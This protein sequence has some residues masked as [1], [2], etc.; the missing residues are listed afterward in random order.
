MKTF[1]DVLKINENATADEIVNAYNILKEKYRENLKDPFNSDKAEELLKKLEIAFKVLGNEENRK[2]YDRDLSNA[3]ANELMN[4]LQKNTDTYN[5]EVQKK[6]EL[7][8]KEVEEIKKKESEQ[9]VDDEELQKEKQAK[10]KFVQNEIEKQIQEQQKQLKIER[11]NRKKIEENKAQEYRS[12][13]RSIGLNVQEPLTVK[14]FFKILIATVI[15][16][17]VVIF[18][19]QIPVVKNAILNSE[20]LK[21]FLELF[22]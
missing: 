21:S 6:E 4:N 9:K 14:R 20:S 12:Y 2:A 10:L 22:K 11:K 1:Y 7:K 17:L 13:L 18:I 3:R 15:V 8:Q 16:L 5:E 19:F